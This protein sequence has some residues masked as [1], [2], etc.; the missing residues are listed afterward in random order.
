VVLR[1]RHLRTIVDG[2]LRRAAASH[3]VATT[4]GDT[5]ST[6]DEQEATHG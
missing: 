6:P 2:L 3:D 4:I 5:R 1:W